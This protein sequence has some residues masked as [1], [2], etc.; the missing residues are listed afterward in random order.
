M[1]YKVVKLCTRAVSIFKECTTHVCCAHGLIMLD[2]SF[3]ATVV[4]GF[5]LY[6]NTIVLLTPLIDE[7]MDLHSKVLLHLRATSKP[8]NNAIE[9]AQSNDFAAATWNV[10]NMRK[11]SE[12]HVMMAAK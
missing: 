8:I 4:L 10:C 11:S 9:L 5:N 7:V 12:R 3:A 2:A 1:V 6:C